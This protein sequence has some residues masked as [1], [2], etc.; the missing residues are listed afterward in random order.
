MAA[1]LVAAG[2]MAAGQYLHA[3]SAHRWAKSQAQHQM[4]KQEEF[5]K[6]GLRWKVADA[7]AAGVHPL[8]ALGAQGPSYTPVTVDSPPPDIASIAGQGISRAIM[9]TATQ[10]EREVQQL[11][12]A[13]MRTELQGKELDNQIRAQQLQKMIQGSQLGPAFPGS[14]H[15]I[16]GQGNSPVISE[17][18]LERTATIPGQGHSEPG[19]VPDVGWAYTA[20]GGVVPLPSRDVKDRIEDNLIQETLHA[21]RNNLMPNFGKG[22][23]P[24]KSALPDG[25]RYWE[26]SY[27]SQAWKPRFERYKWDY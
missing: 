25:A 5:A 7:K 20:D 15:F 6:H 21:V 22:T 27:K 10:Q 12:V 4:A 23:P 19:A 24:P 3:Q 17:K 26:W 11:Q 13:N 1:P 9:A 14:D 2:I 18:P 8:Y 16:P